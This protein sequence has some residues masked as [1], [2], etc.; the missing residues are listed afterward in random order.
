[1]TIEIKF[2]G[3]LAELRHD[4]RRMANQLELDGDKYKAMEAALEPVMTQITGVPPED[5]GK[6]KSVRTSAKKK[7]VVK[8]E[9]AIAA[10][11]EEEA[12]GLP[13][14]KVSDLEETETGRLIETAN[15]E[16][17]EISDCRAVLDQLCAV[18]GMPICEKIIAEF[19][20]QRVRDLKDEDRPRFMK[21]CLEALNG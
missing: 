12:M 20:I 14:P 3:T 4:V 11:K 17:P 19:G 1:M 7:E 16:N 18:K 13:A 5:V 15:V 21:R 2:T 8:H 6:R 9:E 10:A